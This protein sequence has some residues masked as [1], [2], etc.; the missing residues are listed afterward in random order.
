M[1]FDLITFQK[2]II[3]ICKTICTV[4]KLVIM[5]RHRDREQH[6]IQKG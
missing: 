6:K 1:A 3:K 4:T 2:E 5:F